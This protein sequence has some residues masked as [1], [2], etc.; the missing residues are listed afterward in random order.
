MA[1]LG[2][3]LHQT[4][5]GVMLVPERTR[6]AA[7]R[8]LVPPKP[9]T[10]PPPP[11]PPPKSAPKPK[12]SAAPA[13]SKTKS[14]TT[15]TTAAASKSA[16]A[17]ATASAKPP[18]GMVAVPGRERTAPL[19]AGARGTS[20]LLVPQYGA[21]RGT[22]IVPAC[23][24]R[25]VVRPP[26]PKTVPPPHQPPHQPPPQ[27]RRKVAEKEE[28]VAKPAAATPAKPRAK[29][30]D[31][32][33]LRAESREKVPVRKTAS[34]GTA[35][36]GTARYGEGTG[37]L[38]MPASS[39]GNSRAPAA[40]LPPAKKARRVVSDDEREDEKEGSV[41]PRHDRPGGSHGGPYYDSD[42]DEDE[43]EEDDMDGFIVDDDDEDAERVRRDVAREVERLA[44][45]NENRLARHRA[46]ERRGRMLDREDGGR[47]QEVR[48]RAALDAEEAATRRRART[49]ERL[50]DLAEQGIDVAKYLKKLSAGAPSGAGKAKKKVL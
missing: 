47:M 19:P 2:G 13:K 29:V 32:G 17:H 42:E 39:S 21:G 49:L 20:S 33:V 18:P 22:L 1:S 11:P 9:K 15:A 7:K 44:W 23:A 38:V 35:A 16:P 14:A 36:A 43:D 28:P 6:P 27:P 10:V 40:A 48:G 50:Q 31:I 5:R 37:R 46:A 26:P 30:V 34:A 45:G 4:A 8:V 3:G 12:A 41:R 24:A 25:G